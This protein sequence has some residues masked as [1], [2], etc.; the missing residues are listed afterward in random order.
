[1]KILNTDFLYFAA[2]LVWFFGV[3]FPFY[4]V[5]NSFMGSYAGSLTAFILPASIYLWYIPCHLS[6]LLNSKYLD[7]AALV[8]CIR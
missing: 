4:G 7:S 2:L 6:S 3:A 8:S 1:M 5:I